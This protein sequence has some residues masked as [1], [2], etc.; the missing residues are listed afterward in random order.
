M[1]LCACAA[2]AYEPIQVKDG[3]KIAGVVKAAGASPRQPPHPVFKNKEV[4]GNQVEN[5]SLIL[6]PAGGLRDAVV[7][8]VDVKRGRAVELETANELDNRKC[9][10]APHVQAAS[11]GQWLELKNTDSILHN[12]DARLGSRTLFNVGLW[13]GRHLRKPMAY[14]GVVRINCDVH[15]WM[16]AYVVVTEHP[17][18]AVT[19]L[20]GD[21]EI[22]GVPPGD[23]TLRAWHERLGT[24]DKQVR[25]QAGKTTHADLTFD[26]QGK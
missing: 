16:S 4:C 24:L 6:G 7:T 23:Y 20:Y 26:A 8:L 25:V 22:E 9:R 13:P 10:F 5:E 18:H 19:D 3:G 17:Y 12:D 2:W 14:A 15:P 1:L 21:Y 11:V